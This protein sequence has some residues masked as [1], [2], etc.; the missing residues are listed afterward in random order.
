MKYLALGDS[1]TVGEGV[2]ISDSFP[3]QLF[4]LF[5]SKVVFQPDVVART[6]WTTDDLI[7]ALE[8]EQI[9]DTFDLVTLLIGVNN[10]YRG[11]SLDAYQIEFAT[12]LQKAIEFAGGDKSRVI[13]L[14]I[15]NWGVTP[16]AIKEGRDP[17]QVASDIEAFNAVNKQEALKQGVAYVDIT[18]I[19]LQAADQNSLIAA[20]GLHPS[21]KMYALWVE[22]IKSTVKKIFIK[23]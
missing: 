22:E 2:E 1:Y 16:F 6:G 17:I 5:E 3:Y 13:V 12:L 7:H 8:E 9:S 19:S 10:Q 4:G 14:S 15:P 20:D 21:A 18:P 23:H 11:Y